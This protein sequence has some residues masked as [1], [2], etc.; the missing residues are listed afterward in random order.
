MT[1]KEM[2]RAHLTLVHVYHAMSQPTSVG[3]P[4]IIP[5]YIT[6]GMVGLRLSQKL[7]KTLSLWDPINRHVPVHNQT[8]SSG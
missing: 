7:S 6:T 4:Y 8:C 2:I 5:V 3:G 1:I